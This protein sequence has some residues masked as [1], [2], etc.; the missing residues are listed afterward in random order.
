MEHM[1]DYFIPKDSENSNSAHH[2]QIRHEIQ[3][4]LDT[5]DDVEFTKEEILAVLEKFDPGQAPG[6]DGQN[7]EILLK[8]FKGFPTFLTRLHNACLRK[9]FFPK[10]WKR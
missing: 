7:N 10:Q 3:D 2:K 1:M 8:A 9:G 4:P 6:E 5:P